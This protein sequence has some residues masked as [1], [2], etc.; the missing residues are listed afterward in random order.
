MMSTLPFYG[1]AFLFAF[2][3][4]VLNL[5]WRREFLA[6]KRFQSSSNLLRSLRAIFLFI[7]L[8]SLVFIALAL[9][10]VNDSQYLRTLLEGEQTK[11]TVTHVAKASGRTPSYSAL[12]EYVRLDGR[13]TSFKSVSPWNSGLSVGDS[14]A[15][16]Y[17]QESDRALIDGIQKFD[18]FQFLA[19]SVLMLVGC[20]IPLASYFRQ[21][22]RDQ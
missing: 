17:L 6:G 3:V 10:T 19:F 22:L 20:S 18:L 9:T 12:V 4:L 13:V 21:T 16:I 8:L 15:V 2:T 5:L 14:V 7:A 1:F 11:G